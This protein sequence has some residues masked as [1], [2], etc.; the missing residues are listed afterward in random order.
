MVAKWGK[1]WLLIVVG[2][3]VAAWLLDQAADRIKERRG[4]S[5]LTKGMHGAADRLRRVRRRRR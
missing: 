5:D 4:G 1:R 3:P 2:L